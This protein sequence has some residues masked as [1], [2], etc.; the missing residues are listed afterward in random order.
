[1]IKL[2]LLS[3]FTIN[4][5]ASSF[6]EA[7]IELTDSE[8]LIFTNK[9]VISKNTRDITKLKLQLSN[10]KES[11]DGLKSIIE[12]TNDKISKTVSKTN[13]STSKDD[14]DKLKSRIDDIEKKNNIRFTKIEKSLQKL[15][16]LLS[17][18]DAKT[19]KKT[20][21][22]KPKKKTTKV[23]KE[24]SLTAYTAFL[25]AEK[26]YKQKSYEYAIDFYKKSV[27]LDDNSKYLPTILLHAGLCY[28]NSGDKN[29][30]K[31]FLNIL[32]QT[33]PKSKSAK[34]AT[35]ILKKL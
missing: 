13:S 12:S 4:I 11:L 5:F 6:G 34:I 28:K 35:K 7:D 21:K 20:T 19:V 27:E 2:F 8:K 25:K 9:K 26:L 29:S 10:I 23:K 24:P 17:S 3:L 1:M 16:K 33:Y 22:A 15:I 32:V 31:K 14:I 30:A 18:N